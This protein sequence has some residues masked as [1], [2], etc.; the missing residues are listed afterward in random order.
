MNLYLL[1]GIISASAALTTATTL[2]I[3]KKVRLYRK[4]R[5]LLPGT[6]KTQ[7]ELD[8]ILKEGY[9]HI[10]TMLRTSERI[11]D[12]DIS[13]NIM[14]IYIF[15]QKIYDDIAEQPHDLNKV[16]MFINYYMETTRKI[17]EKYED[18]YHRRKNLKGAD[19]ILG[20]IEQG[21]V[22]IKESFAEQYSRLFEEDFLNIN[23]ELEVLRKTL[24]LEQ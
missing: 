22:E 18:I 10:K 12:E 14:D 1:I 23:I 2:F 21:F 9:H 13:N 7:A 15:A 8:Q 6:S 3:V 17:V 4:I 5:K 11:P 19:K 16:R 20:N 24:K